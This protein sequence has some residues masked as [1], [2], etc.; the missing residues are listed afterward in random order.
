MF[1]LIDPK[2]GKYIKKLIL[3]ACQQSLILK[4]YST[5]KN[6]NQKWSNTKYK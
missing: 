5:Q 1:L 2:G 4:F 6:S 3:V